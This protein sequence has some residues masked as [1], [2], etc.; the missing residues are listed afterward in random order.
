LDDPYPLYAEV[1]ERRAVRTPHDGVALAQHH[2]V[3]AV[4]ADARFGKVL[5][6]RVPLKATRVMS[7]E[8]LFLDPPDHARLRR[9]VAP[10]FTQSS[11]A[12]MRADIEAI[13]Q[14]LL[15][16]SATRIDL[17]GDFAYPLPFA[18]VAALLGI[19]EDDQP[20]IAHW[21]QTLTA[22]LDA[23]APIKMRDLPRG[24][25]AIARGELHPIAAVR[26]TTGIVR[27]A[28][29]RIAASKTA[30]A[31]PLCE[32]LVRGIVDG[33]L[34]DDEAAATWLMLAIAGHETTANL[35]GNSVFALL[36]H[37]DVLA[38]LTADPELV[39]RA[40][41]ECL[42]YD[43][44]VAHTPRVA[45]DDVAIGDVTIRRGEVVLLLLA[46]A[47][48]D[49]EAFP[50][51]D[52]LDLAR[53]KTPSHVGFAHGIHFCVGAALARLEMETAL[54]VV[55]PRIALDAERPPAVRRP[56]VAVRGLA[57]FP[58]TLRALASPRDRG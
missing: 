45:H 18:V 12:A 34:N 52:R 40:V 17:V 24:I 6:P 10:T 4:L 3:I 29:S 25:K 22:S 57:E 37:P 58:V 51:P 2:D 28:Q 21:S 55:L 48:R 38:Q 8:F 50:D 26:A 5:I 41:D 36:E 43:T 30:P 35:I 13:A 14:S 44:P 39:P 20:Q 56:T 15:P 53:P 54:N 1:R 7:R 9:V 11:V 19:P 23:P 32:T 49:P 27:Y 46:A 47:N 33:E 16:A 42:R 31:T